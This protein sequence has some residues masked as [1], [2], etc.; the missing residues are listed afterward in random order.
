M[1]VPQNFHTG[2]GAHPL[3]QWVVGVKAAE[4]L[5][6]TSIHP[7][8][9]RR[10]RMSEPCLCLARAGTTW[11]VPC[12]ES[13]CSPWSE[14]AAQCDRLLCYEVTPCRERPEMKIVAFEF[15]SLWCVGFWCWAKLCFQKV[16]A[17]EVVVI[18]ERYV[19]K[20]LS[21]I[22]EPSA[23][24]AKF[25]G[26]RSSNSR[27]EISG[28]IR[29]FPVTHSF[30]VRCASELLSSSLSSSQSLVNVGIFFRVHAQLSP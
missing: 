12:V 3:G 30:Y 14:S 10:P 19:A 24:Y 4:T 11:R 8:L 22:V 16:G 18:L 6:L 27:D 1:I 28:W 7:R 17:H 29:Q 13:L 2:F 26:N 21:L 23:V 20:L 25:Y 9:M 15:F 5:R